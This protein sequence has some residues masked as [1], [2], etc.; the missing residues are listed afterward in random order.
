MRLA[1]RTAVTGSTYGPGKLIVTAGLYYVQ[2]GGAKPWTVRV[3]D[4]AIWVQ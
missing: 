2:G 4:V 3:D 1:D